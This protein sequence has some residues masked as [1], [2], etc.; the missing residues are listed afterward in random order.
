MEPRLCFANRMDKEKGYGLAILLMKWL[1]YQITSMP[2][3][4]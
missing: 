1:W 2:A 3:L 4:T